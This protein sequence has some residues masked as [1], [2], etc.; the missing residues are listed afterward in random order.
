VPEHFD[1]LPGG[2]QLERVAF[3]VAED[4]Q[5]AGADQRREMGIVQQVL[6]ERRGPAPDV[7]LAVGRVGE[8]Q[9]ELPAGQ[10]G[11]RR[12]G[13]LHPNLQS[14]GIQLRRLDVLSQKPGVAIGLLDADGMD[15]AAAEISHWAEY[16]YVLINNDAEKCRELV[17]NIL[18]AERLKATRRVFL[19]DFVRQLIV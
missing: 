2:R 9:I 1:F 3:G 6:R 5:A 13:V 8:N 14:G 12:E 16:D 11:E 7:F 17:H 19:H 18:K 4:E 15:R 10:L